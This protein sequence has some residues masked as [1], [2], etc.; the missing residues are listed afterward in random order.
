MLPSGTVLWGTGE[1]EEGVCVCMAELGAG[2]EV[3]VV[4]DDCL[5]P[6]SCSGHTPILGGGSSGA[7]SGPCCSWR[8]APP[9]DSVI[10]H[11]LPFSPQPPTFLQTPE[12]AQ[13]DL[14]AIHLFLI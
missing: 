6:T 14:E 3:G 11:I 9:P 4:G 10:Y 7:A 5:L 8:V 2:W 12:R 1:V 13:T